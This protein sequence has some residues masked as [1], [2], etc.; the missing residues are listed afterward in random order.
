[1][2]D[3]IIILEEGNLP[4]PRCENCDMFVPWRALNGRHKSTMMC[5]MGAER[6]RRRLAEAVIRESTEMAFEVYGHQTQSVLRFKY[7]GRVMMEGDDDWPTVAGNLEKARKIWGRMQGILR[8]AGATPRISGNFFKAVV[9]QVLLFWAEAW[10]VTPKME[11]A[12]RAFLHGAARRLT[13]HL[14]GGKP[15]P[16]KMRKL[17]HVCTVAGP[18]WPP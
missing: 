14:G 1:M 11:R 8:R 4:H 12:L 17:R 5:K 2:R 16:S 10:V 18:Q 9:Q 13:G 15:P 6:K 7:L 3:T